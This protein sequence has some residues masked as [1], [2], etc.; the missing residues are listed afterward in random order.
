MTRTPRLTILALCAVLALAG[1]SKKQEQPVA[2]GQP[3]AG[4]GDAR[5]M[6]A[7]DGGGQMPPGDA[8]SGQMPPGHEQMMGGAT[9]ETPPPSGSPNSAAGVTW[10][11]P[12]AW[13]LAPERPMRVATYLVKPAGGDPEGGE[14]GVFY[15]GSTQGG[16][17]E[18]NIARWVG[19]FENASPPE[20]SAKTVNG[21]SVSFVKVHGD[22][23]APSGPMMQSTGARPDYALL[24]AI[25]NGPQGS[26][27]FKLTGPRKT[28]E[29]ARGDFEAMVGTMKKE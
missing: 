10:T 29:A 26:V 2:Q 6:I 14:C 5:G 1:C 17:V 18:S 19:Q 27:F 16:D 20:R 7:P 3:G 22:F 21:L 12:K 9:I 28:I 24:G 4:A 8:G 11:V 23:L 15:F 13:S 25:V